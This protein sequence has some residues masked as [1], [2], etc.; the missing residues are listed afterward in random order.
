MLYALYLQSKMFA[1]LPIDIIAKI[2]T[3]LNEHDVIACLQ[4]AKCFSPISQCITD[5]VINLEFRINKN[6]YEMISI[7]NRRFPNLQTVTLNIYYFVEIDVNLIV[8]QIRSVLPHIIFKAII[9]YCQGADRIIHD[10]PDGTDVRLSHCFNLRLDPALMLGKHFSYMF[11]VGSDNTILKHKDLLNTV[12][13]IIMLWECNVDLTCVDPDKTAITLDY[14]NVQSV[15][16][17]EHTDLYK[18]STVLVNSSIEAFT[19]I[20]AAFKQDP[21]FRTRSVLKE[22]KFSAYSNNMRSIKCVENKFK[23]LIDIIPT[24]CQVTI[25]NICTSLIYYADILANS[26]IVAS[27]EVNSD[28]NYRAALAVKMMTKRNHRIVC[29]KPV[30]KTHYATLGDIW[31]NMTDEERSIWGCVIICSNHIAS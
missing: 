1:N 14:R 25:T 13:H 30:K 17:F 2:G 31:Q 6:I 22:V 19:D 29:D 18:V 4:A 21:M 26:G 7:V 10:L 3:F 11:L 5:Y 20:V 23:E 28:A 24:G 9:R 12:E 27:I 8:Y 16:S 15:S